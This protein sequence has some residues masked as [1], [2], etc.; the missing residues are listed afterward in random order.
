MLSFDD[1][2]MTPV[3]F[4][5]ERGWYRF[6]FTEQKDHT[7]RKYVGTG[8]GRK[9]NRW[10]LFVGALTSS[11]GCS[12]WEGLILNTCKVVLSDRTPSLLSSWENLMEVISALSSPRR[13]S[14]NN[15]VERVEWI[16]MMVPVS[17]A[18]AMSVPDLLR[19]N[20]CLIC[21]PWW[22]WPHYALG[23]G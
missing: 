11:S 23:P 20:E 2:P 12:C 7:E 10:C 15:A 9:L 19:V 3:S 17:D 1:H 5:S 16:L 14:N 13:N 21:E 8:T 22:C 4:S 6:V 18:D